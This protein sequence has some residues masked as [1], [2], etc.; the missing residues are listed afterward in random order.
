MPLGTNR[1]GR[2]ITGEEGMEDENEGRTLLNH[3]N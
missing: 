3:H 2:R 1:K